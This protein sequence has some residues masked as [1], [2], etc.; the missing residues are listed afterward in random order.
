M[1]DVILTYGWVRSSYAALRNLT[2]H[3]V[4]VWVADQDSIGMC[5]WSR[6]KAGFSQYP[7]YNVNQE[8]FINTLV[9]LASTIGAKYIL[10]SHN[11]TEILAKYRH[12]LPFGSDRLIPPFEICELF[13]DKSRAWKLAESLGLAV[14]RK[15]V[16]SVISEIEETA[17]KL[18]LTKV[19]V[20]LLTGNSAK[21]V[22]FA[23]S[24][25]DAQKIA[26]KL[27]KRY[28]LKPDRYPQIEERIPG[29]DVSCAVL[30]WDGKPIVE[31]C[32][33]SIR[34]KSVNGGTSTFREVFSH[35]GIEQ[36]SHRL[37]T[38]IKW[39]GL[40]Q[41]DFKWCEK[42]N[43]FW[44]IE[45]NPRLW[46]SLSLAVS[47]GIEFPYLLWLC[48]E[49][50]PIFAKEYVSRVPKKN[51]SRAQWFLGDL[52][53]VL[54]ALTCGDFKRV[55]AVIK[56]SF[57]AN[58]RDDLPK[59]DPFVFWGQLINYIQRVIKYRSFNPEQPGTVH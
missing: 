23:N 27:V 8:K 2:D 46:G 17:K 40:A 58:F 15:L 55:A 5:Q 22:Y 12:I 53:V 33:K 1:I 6:Y 21:G 44:F 54:A 16:Y 39:H 37:F 31:F 47:S 20:K 48:A 49:K 38:K 42:T 36:A 43:K 25:R 19:V 24:G 14:P 45:V 57:R 41:V 56:D 4:R 18:G 34:E 26:A 11:E 10:P 30:Y 7:D 3:G 32:H 28:K 13:N 35:K 59:S 29:Y 51:N 52:T 50:G 9:D